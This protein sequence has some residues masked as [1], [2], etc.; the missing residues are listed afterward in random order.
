L[1]GWSMFVKVRRYHLAKRRSI[2]ED[3]GDE[4]R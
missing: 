1:T 2:V 4:E 3:E